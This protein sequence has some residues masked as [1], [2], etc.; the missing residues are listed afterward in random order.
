M[1]RIVVIASSNAGI[2][3]ALGIKSRLPADEINLVLPAGLS[4]FADPVGPASQRAAACLPDMNLLTG[5]DIGIIEA[6]ELMPDLAKNEVVVSSTRGVLP[7]R[8][9]HLVVETQATARVPRAIGAMANVFA[10]PQ[11]GFAANPHEVDNAL[12]TAASQNTPALVVGAGMAA[13]DA[14]LGA[15]EAGCQVVWLFPGAS[16]EPCLASHLLRYTLKELGSAVRFV[17]LPET[18]IED[19]TF[20]LS[21]DG[22]LLEAVVTPDGTPYPAG[23]CLWTAPMLTRHPLLREEGFSL[24][25]QGRIEVDPALATQVSLIGSGAAMPS[26]MAAGGTLPLPVASGG[27]ESALAT[28]HAC[29]WAVAEGKIPAIGLMGVQ[30]AA[31]SKYCALRAGFGTREAENQNLE[32][33]QAVQCLSIALEGEAETADTV[34]GQVAL[35]IVCHKPTHTIIGVQVLGI[36]APEVISTA[37][38]DLAIAALRAGTPLAHLARAEF[39]GQAADLLAKTATI[40]LRK[41][42]GGVFGIS[43]AELLASR[44]AGAEFF[45]LDLRH[46]DEWERAHLEGAYNIPFLQLKKRLQDEVPRF[47]PLVLVSDTSE[48]AYAAASRLSALGAV[49]LYVLDGGM[50]L[51]PYP[52]ATKDDD[53]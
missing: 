16:A 41:M 30:R 31:N 22:T 50:R 43:P 42:A 8:F 13:L 44:Q 4:S 37:V 10:W 52:T 35:R 48:A 45:T 14:V 21:P 3:C 11:E 25:A 2:E 24:D 46:Q 20:A 28:A 29:A 7:V 12:L 51:W 33:E 38:F 39:A 32:T 1:K 49:D 17:H 27:P 9:H 40:A 5:R 26:F 23:V 6:H 34:V 36:N 19:L 15:H 53:E 18:G 47:T